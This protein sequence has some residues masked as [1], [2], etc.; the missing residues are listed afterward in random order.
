MGIA[1]CQLRLPTAARGG[2]WAGRQRS[3]RGAGADAPG[4]ADRSSVPHPVWAARHGIAIFDALH[5]H[6]TVS[7]AILQAFDLLELDGVDYRLQPFSKRKARL[8]QAAGPR[9]ARDRVERAHRRR[10]RTRVP[11]GLR[12][13]PGGHRVE[14]PERGVPLGAVARLGKGQEPGQSGDGA[15]GSTSRD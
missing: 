7:D 5:R 14:A 6:G 11:A 15:R 4:N 10:R 8:A 3:A 12:D 9:T 13:G 1:P 2:A